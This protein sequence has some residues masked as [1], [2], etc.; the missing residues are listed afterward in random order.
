VLG[1]D[2]DCPHQPRTECVFMNVAA[3]IHP[4]RA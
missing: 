2:D 1:G 3:R 4:T